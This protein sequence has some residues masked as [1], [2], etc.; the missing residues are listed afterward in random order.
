MTRFVRLICLLVIKIFYREIGT[1]YLDA[2]KKPK[3]DRPTLVVA[4][5][6]NGLMD[7]IVLR[8]ALGHDVG[9]LA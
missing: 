2:D 1:R 8:I 9:F 4:N 6:P 7:P 5:H 3:L